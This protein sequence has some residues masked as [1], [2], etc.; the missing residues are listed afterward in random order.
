M[1]LIHIG[2]HSRY[3]DQATPCSGGTFPISD[4]GHIQR[5]GLYQRG[6]HKKPSSLSWALFGAC[7]LC[8]ARVCVGHLDKA[9]DLPYRHTLNKVSVDTTKVVAALKQAGK[10]VKK[11]RS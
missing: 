10:A 11:I 3:L 2:T 6:R 5:V 9:G 4:F 8:N 7:P 1:K